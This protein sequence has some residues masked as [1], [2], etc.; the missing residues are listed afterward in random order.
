MSVRL[1]E[2]S[3]EPFTDFS[4]PDNA[5]AMRAA[6]AAVRSEFGRE[7]PLHIGG[8]TFHT[9]DLLKS[10][11]PSQPS[12]TVG[13][14]HKATRE[15]AGQAVAVADAC[16]AKW[17]RTP[18]GTRVEML[19]RA[20]A[21]LRRRKFEF[22][23]W[24]VLEAGKTWIEAE[25][26]TCEAIDFCEYYALQMLKWAEPEPLPQVGGEH[27]EL[28]YLPLGVGIVIPPWNF[29]LAILAGMTVAALVAGNTVV[30]KPSSDTPTVAAKFV[31]VLA[32]AGFPAECCTLLVGGGGEIGDLLV[33]HPR[34]RF[35]SFTGSREVGLRINELA[36]RPHAGRSGSNA[37]PPK[38]AARTPSSSTTRPISKPPRRACWLRP[39][40]IRARSARPARAPLS[41]IRFTTRSS[42][43]SCPW[44]RRSRPARART[45]A[46]TWAR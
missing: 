1:W 13:L 8:A 17:S 24:L 35:V 21:D 29:S 4:K 37:S 12:E 15:L 22:N 18:A 6:L 19:R 16:F 38:W 44:C 9:G 41:S 14:H 45:R 3:N 25:A 2:F 11:N 5:A 30:L 31:E 23:A 34:T 36:A 46:I 33:A 28:R 43:N 20:A 26:E 7:Y 27:G 42:R 10:V 32:E 40:D 39:S